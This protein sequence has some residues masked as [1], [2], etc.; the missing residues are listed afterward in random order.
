MDAAG[1]PSLGTVHADFNLSATWL[2]ASDEAVQLCGLPHCGPCSDGMTKTG[3]KS[4]TG[5]Q[6][7]HRCGYYQ[8]ERCPVLEYTASL[9]FPRRLKR[10]Q[11]VKD[12]VI[13]SSRLWIFDLP[14]TEIDERNHLSFSRD[15]HP[16]LPAEPQARP[17]IAS[18]THHAIQEVALGPTKKVIPRTTKRNYRRTTHRSI[19]RDIQ[20]TKPLL[21]PLRVHHNMPSP[22]AI[23]L[24]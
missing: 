3:F 16:C 8:F 11:T 18:T 12:N 20:G 10:P 13:E 19:S 6:W 1:S 22:Y 15:F 2:A 23:L 4:F 14:S 17:V 5:Q 21:N 24:H 7:P 9:G